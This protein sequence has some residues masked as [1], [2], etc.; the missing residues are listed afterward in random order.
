LGQVYI[1]VFNGLIAVAFVL[2][3]LSHFYV[4]IIH[5]NVKQPSY[6]LVVLH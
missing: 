2:Q 4:G 3:K 1:I 6:D 5:C